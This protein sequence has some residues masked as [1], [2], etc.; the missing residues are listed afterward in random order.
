[1]DPGLRAERAAFHERSL[2]RRNGMLVKRGGGQIPVDGAEV[3]ESEFVGAVALVP[4]TGFLHGCSLHDGPAEAG[5][6][7][8]KH[9]AG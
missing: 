5:R 9:D 2:L 6:S 4:Q 8:I 3:L 1:M 7:P